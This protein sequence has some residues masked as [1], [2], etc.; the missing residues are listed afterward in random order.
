MLCC[1]MGE[2]V[3]SKAAFKGCAHVSHMYAV[4]V[5]WLDYQ[6]SNAPLVCPLEYINTLAVNHATSDLYLGCTIYWVMC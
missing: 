2:K 6:P 1:K 3:L 4:V 5:A